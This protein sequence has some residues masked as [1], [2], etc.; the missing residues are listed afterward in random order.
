MTPEQLQTILDAI[1][2]N[3]AML[4]GFISALI[5]AATWRG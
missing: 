4:A 5:F 3:C 1:N 2:N